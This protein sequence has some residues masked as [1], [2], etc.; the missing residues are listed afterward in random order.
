MGSGGELYPGPL[1]AL[2]GHSCRVSQCYRTLLTTY[3]GKLKKTPLGG[4][5]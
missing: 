2:S 4:G 1:S 5:V 3:K